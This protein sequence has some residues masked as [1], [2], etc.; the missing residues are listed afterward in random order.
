MILL[1]LPLH[2][3]RI[4]EA[5]KSSLISGK[6]I[7]RLLIVSDREI[8]R[9]PQFAEIRTLLG[10]IAIIGEPPY[11]DV[12]ADSETEI[13]LESAKALLEHIINLGKKR[14]NGSTLQR[15]G[16][17]GIRNSL[18]NNHDPE[19]RTLLQVGVEDAVLADEIFTTLMG[20]QVEPRRDF[21]YLNA[22]H[23]SNLD[24]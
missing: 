7:R 5:L 14:V 8:F 11:R 1:T 19:K 17:N 4:T 12:G 3:T 13:V 2:P 22:L 16:R 9:T 24:I 23:V 18:G 15:P 20:D 21:I 10:Q 6:T